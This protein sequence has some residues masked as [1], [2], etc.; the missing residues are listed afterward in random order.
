MFKKNSNDT[1]DFSYK[2]GDVDEVIDSRGNSVILLRSIAWGDHEEKLELRKWVIDINKEQALK[3]VSFLTDEGPHN[4]TNTLI[5]LGYGKTEEILKTLSE[6]DD[7]K[8]AIKNYDK[9]QH[10]KKSGKYLDPKEILS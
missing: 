1:K 10:L 6:R 9:P 3:G 5:K 2:I 4:L 7:F 8:D